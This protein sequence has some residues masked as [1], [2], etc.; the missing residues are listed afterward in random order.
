MP[1][2]GGIVRPEVRVSMRNGE[3]QEE[4]HVAPVEL[5]ILG[6]YEGLAVAFNVVGMLGTLHLL[7][8]R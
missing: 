4:E 1:E 3:G 8:Q 6:H 7:P 5:L 2:G